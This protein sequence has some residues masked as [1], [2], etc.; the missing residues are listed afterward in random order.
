MEVKHI[1]Y[2]RAECEILSKNLESSKEV[3]KFL[4]NLYLCRG[5]AGMYC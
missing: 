4:K 2:N 5:T 1:E 3:L